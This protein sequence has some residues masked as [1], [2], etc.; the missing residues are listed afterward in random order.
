MDVLPTP[1]AIC[2]NI[3]ITRRQQTAEVVVLDENLAALNPENFRRCLV[4][5][6]RH[7]ATLF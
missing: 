5:T 1:N 7:A 2:H 4:C 3:A 6:V